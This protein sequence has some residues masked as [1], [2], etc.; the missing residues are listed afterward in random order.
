MMRRI[1]SLALLAVILA[2]GTA[3]THQAQGVRTL[4]PVDEAPLDPE[5]LAF[6]T[7]LQAAVTK[8]D[9]AALMEV[10]HPEIKHGF[11]GDDGIHAFKELWR[12]EDPNSE[13]WMQLVY[14]LGLG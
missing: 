9:A 5:F 6:R 13:L 1:P 4:K 3:G 12:H 7:R 2:F 8:H 10:V 11:G 14:V